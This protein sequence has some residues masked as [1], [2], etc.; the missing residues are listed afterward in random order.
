MT[1]SCKA[2]V[3]LACSPT[4]A[5]HSI[6]WRRM[7]NEPRGH[8]GKEKGK[9]DSLSLLSSGRPRHARSLSSNEHGRRSRRLLSRSRRIAGSRSSNSPHHFLCSLLVG[10]VTGSGAAGKAAEG[11]CALRHSLAVSM[12]G[13]GSKKR[14]LAQCEQSGRIHVST[15]TC[16]CCCVI[17]VRV[18]HGKKLAGRHA[19]GCGMLHLV[20]TLSTC[21]ATVKNLPARSLHLLQLL[22]RTPRKRRSAVMWP[23][24]L[25]CMLVGCPLHRSSN[26]VRAG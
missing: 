11:G 7:T 24:R 12:Q 26:G 23:I 8:S 17:I 15:N 22:A 13:G 19:G 4:M 18:Q 9:M 2:L 16:C 6:Q 14:G 3:P 1:G 20:A 10:C 5:G 21:C 25:G